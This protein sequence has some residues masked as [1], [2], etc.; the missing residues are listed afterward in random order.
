M[1]KTFRTLPE[2]KISFH[3][4]TKVQLYNFYAHGIP[5]DTSGN[6]K[7]EYIAIRSAAAL[8]DLKYNKKHRDMQMV[9]D[10]DN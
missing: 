5:V 6:G 4:V 3:N 1:I 9:D 10:K 7:T 2:G 8:A